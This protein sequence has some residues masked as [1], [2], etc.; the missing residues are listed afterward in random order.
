MRKSESNLGSEEDWIRKKNPHLQNLITKKNLDR[1]KTKKKCAWEN[2]SY[3][4]VN[5]SV[6][7]I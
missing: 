6:S 5:L 4:F 2:T 1:I 7:V 3:N